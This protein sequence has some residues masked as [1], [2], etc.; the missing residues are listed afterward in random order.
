MTSA[1]VQ[2][3]HG[4]LPAQAKKQRGKRPATQAASNPLAN[5]RTSHAH[6]RG[7]LTHPVD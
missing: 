6:V 7:D 3:L 1:I 4:T 5:E 2:R